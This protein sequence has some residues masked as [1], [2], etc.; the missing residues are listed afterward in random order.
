MIYITLILTTNS[1]W[2]QNNYDFQLVETSAITTSV[3]SASTDSQVP[4]AKAVYTALQEGGG[5]SY[6]AGEGIDITNDVISVTG[7]VDTSYVENVE[8]T[9]ARSMNDL[10]DSISGKA[11]ASAVTEEI[12]SAVS[13]KAD[14]SRLGGLSLVKL[15]QAEYDALETKDPNTLYI[16]DNSKP[17]HDYSKDYLTF[18]VTTGGNIKFSGSTTANTLSFSKDN[19]ETWSTADSGT[20]IPV[21]EGDKVL[22]KGTP[23]PQSNKGIGKFSGDTTARYSVEGNAM[24][25]LFGDD[26]KNQTSLEG[27]DYALYRLFHN[28]RL[29]ITSAENMVL[30][31]LNLASNCYNGMFNGCENLTTAPELPAINLATLCYA[32]MFYGCTS[33]TTAPELPATTL[34]ESCYNNMFK[35][36]S[37]LT[38]APELPATTLA[39][40]CYNDMF[41]E[42][43]HLTTAPE[44]PATN[45]TRNCYMGMFAGCSSLTTA[46]ELS[47][48][49]LAN[50]CYN[51]MFAGCSS[52]TAAPELPATTLADSCYNG[53]FSNTNVLPDCTNIDFSSQSV[54]A[55]GGLRGLFS[56]TKLTDAQLD[57]ILKNHGINDYSL[58][59]TTLA[60]GCYQDMF[61]G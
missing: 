32:Y 33:L 31:A 6:T 14:A 22:W 49:T 47:A 34:T 5:S 15:S 19:G 58:P 2:A 8:K 50:S 30:P 60:V 29:L 42:C 25:L 4:S 53:I 11:D 9:V 13:G 48:T 46:P 56:G 17:K 27:K 37:S 24:S 38:T 12:T 45:L 55:S 16:I 1:T 3:T 36:C 28:N 23:T 35:G 39:E 26:F 61:A 40:G 57:A 44:L 43:S 7:K 10:H 52:L 20:T 59:V 54:V 21:A 41:R 18:V 51:T